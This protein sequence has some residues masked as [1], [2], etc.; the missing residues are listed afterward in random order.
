MGEVI[1]QIE[2]MTYCDSVQYLCDICDTIF[3]EAH[4]LLNH[5]IHE[6]ELHETEITFLVKSKE[7]AVA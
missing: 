4:K 5:C 6:H 2:N 3:R 7:K 1:P